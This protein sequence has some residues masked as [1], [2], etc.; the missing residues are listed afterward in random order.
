MPTFN[1]V[2]V[3]RPRLHKILCVIAFALLLS[4]CGGGSGTTAGVGGSG[5]GGTGITLVR[6]NVA[7]VVA[8]L[9]K[10]GGSGYARMVA[11][12][13]SLVSSEAIAQSG[14]VN[15]IKVFGGEKQDVTD[16]QGR[17]D[18]IDVTPSAN[19]IITLI[20]V[21]GQRVDFSIGAVPDKAAVQVNNIVVDARQGNAKPSSVELEDNSAD[22]DS[23]DNGSVDEGSP[24][25]NTQD[26]NSESGGSSGSSGSDSNSGGDEEGDEEGEEEKDNDSED[27]HS[28]SGH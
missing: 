13:A 14:S 15:G 12:M 25:D 27:D 21:D 18:L 16:D 22:G 23:G 19:F 24:D 26:D 2:P 9:E 5:I 4:S 6:G 7:T 3:F 1:G 8:S 28:G 10:E 17:F 20:L 11:R